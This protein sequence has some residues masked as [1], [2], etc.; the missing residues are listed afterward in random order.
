MEEN[1]NRNQSHLIDQVV[2]RIK[3][4]DFLILSRAKLTQGYQSI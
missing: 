3:V 1:P 2:K 4:R